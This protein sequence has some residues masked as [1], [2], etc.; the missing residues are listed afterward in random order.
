MTTLWYIIGVLV[1]ILICLLMWQ[2]KCKLEKYTTCDADDDEDI[3]KLNQSLYP[4][5]TVLITGHSSAPNNWICGLENTKWEL[6]TGDDDSGIYAL[7]SLD[8]DTQTVGEISVGSDSASYSF[9]DWELGSCELTVDQLPDHT[10]T[11]SNDSLVE[12]DRHNH[13]NAWDSAGHN[14]E[15]VNSGNSKGVCSASGDCDTPWDGYQFKGTAPHTHTITTE[16]TGGGKAHSH[17]LLVGYY[18]FYV[19]KRQ[20]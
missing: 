3:I 17:R 7:K 1:I 16:E 6:L 2:P 12:D 20:E 10:H 8:A 9:G 5:G 13:E 19:W 15:T 4:V 14:C 11:I 18:K